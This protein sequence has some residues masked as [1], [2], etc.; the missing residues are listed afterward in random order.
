M[1]AR[2]S[3]VSPAIGL[4]KS[5]RRGRP[6]DGNI[7]VLDF[8]LLGGGIAS[9]VDASFGNAAWVAGIGWPAML[10]S[11]AAMSVAQ[12]E[13]LG[14][15]RVSLSESA[16]DALSQAIG[17]APGGAWRLGRRRPAVGRDGTCQLVPAALARI[18]HSCLR[19][20]AARRVGIGAAM[21]GSDWRPPGTKHL[22]P[23][24]PGALGATLVRRS[25][26]D[27]MSGLLGFGLCTLAAAIC[28]AGLAA[29]YLAIS[30]LPAAA[31]RQ[32]S[33]QP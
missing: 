25:E 10:I 27:W 29:F 4:E 23:V 21:R 6:V 7:A 8:A 3:A 2:R 12:F 30:Q 18:G 5:L 11:A 32:D 22:D 16:T 24:C 33:T 26:R 28:S 15:G 31:A 14:G 17:R 9:A 20:R 13:A 19:A 1:N